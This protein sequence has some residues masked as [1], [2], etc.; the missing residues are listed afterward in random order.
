MKFL[1]NRSKYETRC[2]ASAALS[3]LAAIVYLI[4][5]L[6][7][8]LFSF[9]VFLFILLGAA[10]F[11]IVA[12]TRWDIAALIPTI[13]AATGLGLH[14]QDRVEMF[15]YMATGV[16][17]MGEKGAIL[18][19]VLVIMALQLAAVV[20]GCAACFSWRTKEQE[21]A[22][23]AQAKPANTRRIFIAS[24]VA[25]ALIAVLV[26]AVPRLISSA[27]KEVKLTGIEIAELPARTRYSIHDYFDGT[28]MKVNA[29][30]SDGTK[31]EITGYA[32]GPTE[33]LTANH[34][35]AFVTYMGIRAAVPITVEEI[36]VMDLTGDGVS[37]KLL[38]HGEAKMTTS[39]GE[40]NGTWANSGKHIAVILDGERFSAEE[41]NGQYN[42]TITLNDQSYALSGKLQ[43][44]LLLGGTFNGT[45]VMGDSVVVLAEDGTVSGTFGM[46][47]IMGT[48]WERQ[49]MTL[50]VDIVYAIPDTQ[51]QCVAVKDQ[52]VYK[53]TLGP[54]LEYRL[55]SDCVFTP[56]Q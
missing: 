21:E 47:P 15:A 19:I 35:E 36:T 2:A 55:T 4:Y 25:V 54:I 41:S 32:I 18:W 43:E 28:G 56:A 6:I 40:K 38:E 46:I 26:L 12:L 14:L 51:Q 39:E 52:G 31:G 48:T 27:P 22:W 45:S 20:I 24:A 11:G 23:K 7:V 49:G 8:H 34:T 10:G 3:L 44:N 50:V 13:L 37:L 1:H 5:T 53:M 9:P 42:L 29:V 30:Y 16:Y 17:G 33:E